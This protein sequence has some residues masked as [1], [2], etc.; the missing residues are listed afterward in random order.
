[1]DINESPLSTSGAGGM[2]IPRPQRYYLGAIPVVGC[3]VV[4]GRRDG[5]ELEAVY[6][7]LDLDLVRDLRRHVVVHAD[8]P[9]CAAA[10]SR[11]GDSEARLLE[12]SDSGS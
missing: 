1:M 11:R 8:P 5:T 2:K 3:R 12:A 10:G 4:T 7:L 6:Q 9:E